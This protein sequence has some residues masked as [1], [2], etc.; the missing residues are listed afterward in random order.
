MDKRGR[1]RWWW[2]LRRRRQFAWRTHTHTTHTR[3]PRSRRSTRA[4]TTL[5]A[6]H[7]RTAAAAASAA[8]DCQFPGG[9]VSSRCSRSR[10]NMRFVGMWVACGGTSPVQRRPDPRRNTRR[11]ARGP[12]LAA[13]YRE[14]YRPWMPWCTAY[15]MSACAVWPHV[16]FTCPCSCA[17]VPR[18]CRVRVCVWVTHIILTDYVSFMD[19]QPYRCH[20]GQP[21]QLC[22]RGNQMTRCA[23]KCC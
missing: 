12:V 6:Q 22:E 20:M 9:H 23:I 16:E 2:R 8:R 19:G 7:W 3:F 17:R 5:P 18:V 11:H 15:D 4:L 21:I 14:I 10:I 1:Q 13:R